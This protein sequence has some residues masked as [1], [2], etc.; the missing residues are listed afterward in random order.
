MKGMI[1]AAAA[2]ALAG[3][4]SATEAPSGTND[5]TVS[6]DNTM[7]E[8]LPAS[9]T[10]VANEAGQSS[11][12]CPLPNSRNWKA[13]VNAMPGPGAQRTLIVVGEVEVGSDGYGGRL[14]ATHL[15]KMNPPVQH[16][17]LN[18]VEKA[19]AKKG[20]QEVRA[21]L[22]NAGSYTAVVVD[23]HGEVAARIE[24]IIEAQ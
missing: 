7:N 13:W 18:M 23:C 4:N 8:A 2:L 24:P 11:I 17:D 15:D 16:F 22:G 14:T 3:C 1:M 5:N 10:K 9:D 6:G 20:W 12:P 19:G 21:D